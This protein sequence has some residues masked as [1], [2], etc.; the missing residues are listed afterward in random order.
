MPTDIPRPTR[1]A[2]YRPPAFLVDEIALD[3]RLD[4]KATRVKSRL[5]VRRNGDHAEPLKLDGERL[6]PISVTMDGRIL[7]PS[8]YTI[9]QEGLTVPGALDAFVLETEVEI[10]PEANKAL[11][12]LYM[13]GGRFCTQCEAEGFRKITW[14]PDRPDVLARFTVRVEAAAEFRHLLSNGNLVE[15]GEGPPGR[16]YA[17]WKDPFPKPSYLFALVAGELDVVE[18]AFTTMSGRDVALRIFV[19]PGMGPRAVYAMDC[20]KRAMRWDE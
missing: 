1:L 11:D 19:D 15:A 17:V 2:D 7:E 9:H 5:V 13:S 16:H 10:D 8:E 4:A 18:D 12:G 6:G 14:F 3:F 20:L